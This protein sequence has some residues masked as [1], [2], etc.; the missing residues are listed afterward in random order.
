MG[1][2]SFGVVYRGRWRNNYV[3]V[4]HIDTEA[5]RKAFTVEV[6]QLSRVNHPNI[7]KLFGAC[8]SNP[9]C[10]VMEFAEGGS[11]YNGLIITLYII[12]IKRTSYLCMSL[13]V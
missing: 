12:S 4:K 7:V 2:G 3:A 13:S 8:T 1:K 11:L 9:V 10:L 5:E 6:R